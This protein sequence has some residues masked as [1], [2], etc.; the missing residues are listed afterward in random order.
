LRLFYRALIVYWLLAAIDGHAKN[1]SVFLLPH[2]RSSMSP[3]YDILSAHPIIAR[4][5]LHPREAKMAMAVVGKNR[6]YRY[7]QIEARHWLS[8]A[9]KVRF[10]VAE[11]EEI[12]HDCAMRGPDVLRE[13]GEQLPDGFPA[14]VAGPIVR[15]VEGHLRSM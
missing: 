9:R 4:K 8:T 2:G 5:Q 7:S 6:H 10:P 1:F 13:I 15:D 14:S 3:F 12:L 11:A